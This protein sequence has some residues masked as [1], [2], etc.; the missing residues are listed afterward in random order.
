ML[1]L[2]AFACFKDDPDGAMEGYRE[3]GFHIERDVVPPALCDQ[4]IEAANKLPLAVGGDYR[5]A[6]HPHRT[7]DLFFQAM[8]QPRVLAVMRR[9]LGER[10][11]G[12]QTE[13]FYGRPGTRGFAAHQDN[14]FVEAPDGCFGSAWMSL[15]DITPD[16]GAL[17]AYPGSHRHGLL[18]TRPLTGG[19]GEGQDPNARNEESVLPAEDADAQPVTVALPKGA[20]LFLNGWVVHGSWNNTSDKNRYA[21]LCT[22][23]RDQA[24]FRAGNYARRTPIPLLETA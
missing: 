9:M 19:A 20:V 18:P 22:Y 8:N 10:V 3:R 5:P 13:F 7:D 17:Y 16:M 24:P 11:N 14:F 4:L 6:M 2:D 12:L 15:T 1:D 23:L 21:L